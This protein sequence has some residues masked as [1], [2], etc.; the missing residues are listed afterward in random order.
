VAEFYTALGYK[1][2]ETLPSIPV[3][4]G[5]I[6]MAN[7]G[8]GTNTSQFFLVTGNQVFKGL[9]GKHTA[10]GK[11]IHGMDVVDDLNLVRPHQRGQGTL[12][13]KVEI[14]VK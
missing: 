5:V 2:D 10:F 1:F 11:V 8:P 4:R 7:A 6:A 9:N 14:Y 12:M 13:E 3:E